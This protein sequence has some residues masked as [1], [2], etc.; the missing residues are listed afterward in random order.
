MYC[1]V[2][3]F[4]EVWPRVADGKPVDNTS[5]LYKEVSKVID[6][7][8]TRPPKGS[9]P[10]GVFEQIILSHIYLKADRQEPNLAEKKQFYAFVH[11]FKIANIIRDF[12]NIQA[13]INLKATEKFAKLQSSWYNE[14]PS[15]PY[16]KQ[17]VALQRLSAKLRGGVQ[18]TQ[19]NS[20]LKKRTK[21]GKLKI[22][23]TNYPKLDFSL[24]DLGAFIAI[25]GTLL[26]LLGYLHVFIVNSYFGVPFQQYFQASDYIASSANGLGAIFL[27]AF[28]AAAYGFL[29]WSTLSSYSVQ[30]ISLYAQTFSSRA[31]NWILHFLGIGALLALGTVYYFEGRI[32][33]LSFLVASLY[34]GSQLIARFC[35]LFF[36]DHLRA[37]FFLSLVYISTMQ[38]ISDALREIE[39]VLQIKS[40][41]SVRTLEFVD[42][43]YSEPEWY[44]LAITSSFVIMRHKLDGAIRVLPKEDL[45]LIE[46]TPATQSP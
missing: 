23:R 39:R 33:S 1:R 4:V 16:W 21:E 8:L 7:Y 27:G 19:I 18:L 36:S 40:G 5:P 37:L 13:L 24:S 11:K 12:A 42:R 14:T 44:V 10:P 15:V 20:Y 25:S 29:F 6:Y 3:C 26:L 31:H 46:S 30:N 17:K 35:V 2:A 9:A 32:D 45:K 34:V 41:P 43:K 38:T 22:A 28:L